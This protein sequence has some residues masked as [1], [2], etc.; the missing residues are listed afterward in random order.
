MSRI[1]WAFVSFQIPNVMNGI[2]NITASTIHIP[3]FLGSASH[4]ITNS[5]CC[6]YLSRYLASYINFQSSLFLY[7]L[8]RCN[9]IR[10]N[11]LKSF[12]IFNIH[13]TMI[14]PPPIANS[15]PPPTHAILLPCSL[16]PIFTFLIFSNQ[17]DF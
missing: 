17:I 16:L 12:L 4:K 2:F 11:L 5:S 14:H 6:R 3:T 8:Q 15:L 1:S 10:G 13:Y 9:T 7:T